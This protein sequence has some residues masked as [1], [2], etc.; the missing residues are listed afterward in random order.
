M[1][2]TPLPSPTVTAP[3]LRHVTTLR[4]EVTEPIDLGEGADGWRR[5]VP[6]TAGTATGELSGRVLPGGADFQVL[7]PDAVTE[8][9]ARYP[10]ELADGTLIEIVNHGI[11]AGSGADIDRLMRGEPVDPDRIYFRCTPRLRAPR[12]A[13]DWVNRTIF[14][15]TGIR[16]PTAV[17]VE[18][19][20]VG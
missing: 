7:R 9:E 12:G 17:E 4:V 10:I 13:W 19:F 3:A 2:S 6:I 15:G 18:V 8:L 1:T 20:A 16:H 14:I 5:I 11:R